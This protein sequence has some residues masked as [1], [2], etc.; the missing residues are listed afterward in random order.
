MS[1]KHAYENLI[2]QITSLEVVDDGVFIDTRQEDHVV[3][4]A[5]PDIVRLPVVHLQSN[6]D[7]L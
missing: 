7:Y 4:T 3:D 5:C 1:M 2:V 6:N